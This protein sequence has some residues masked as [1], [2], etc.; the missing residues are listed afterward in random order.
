MRIL[1]ILLMTVCLSGFVVSQS[2][3]QL[4][5][6][7]SVLF[8]ST[9]SGSF[10]TVARTTGKILWSLKEANRYLQHRTISMRKCYRHI[11]RRPDR[12]SRARRLCPVAGSMSS[13]TSLCDMLHT[14]RGRQSR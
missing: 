8:I 5:V 1:K 6:H 14:R 13:F 10:Y 7:D 4:S 2:H 11:V 12:Y 3:N 9:L